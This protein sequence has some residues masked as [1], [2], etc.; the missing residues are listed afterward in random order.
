MQDCRHNTKPN[1]DPVVPLAPSRL[2]PTSLEVFLSTLRMTPKVVRW[3]RPFYHHGSST[4]S[5]AGL[6]TVLGFPYDQGWKQYGTSLPC[7]WVF[8]RE[9]SGKVLVPCVANIV[10]GTRINH[11]S[12]RGSTSSWLWNCP[13]PPRPPTRGGV[14]GFVRGECFWRLPR[15]CRSGDS[16]RLP[17]CA[18]KNQLVLVS[19]CRRVL[20]KGYP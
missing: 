14:V 8:S 18:R 6:E 16:D 17:I 3:T 7:T 2:S 10:D 12:D 4:C 15:A 11:N 13:P 19:G 5:R 9:F 20:G 1:R